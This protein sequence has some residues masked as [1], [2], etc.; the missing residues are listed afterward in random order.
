MFVNGTGVRRISRMAYGCNVPLRV[1]VAVIATL[2]VS[3]ATLDPSGAKAFSSDRITVTSHGSGPDVVLIAGLDALA[4]DVCSGVVSDVGGYRFHVVQVSGFGGAPTRGNAGEG[5]VVEPVAREI[6]RYITEEGLRDPAL[7]GLSMG[8]SLAML[9]AAKH[10]GMVSKVM[11]VDMLPFTGLFFG[12]PGSVKSPDDV[13]AIAENRRKQMLDESEESRRTRTTAMVAHMIKNES[14]RTSVIEHGL[15]SD[16][17]VSARAFAEL[18]VLDLRDDLARFKGPVTVLYVHAPLIPISAESTD[19]LYADGFASV[20][21]ATL[22]RVPDAY[23]FIM[24][25]Q[26]ERFARELREFLAGG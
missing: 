26:P 5:A 10:P 12:P 23:H 14:L 18:I 3:C 25:D 11:V 16:R 22:K 19:K 4:T 21:R 24:L 1:L 13:R 8:G 2:T 20:P 7:V 9:T 6:A 17:S 15:A